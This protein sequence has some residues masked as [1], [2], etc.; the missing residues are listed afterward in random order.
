MNRNR[1]AAYTAFALSISAVGLGC[2]SAP[3]SG[4]ADRA[5]TASDALSTC[6]GVPRAVVCNVAHCTAKGWELTPVAAGTACKTSAGVAG[7]CS[8]G[9]VGNCVGAPYGRA[10]LFPSYYV[11]TLAY[12]PPG[13]GS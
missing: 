1:L 12:T 11:V 13:V 7:T 6:G 3:S 9:T 2:S 4:D 5:D 8:G 10:E